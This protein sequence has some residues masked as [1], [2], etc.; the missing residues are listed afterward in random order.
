MGKGQEL[1]GGLDQLAEVL[2]VCP[3][4]VDPVGQG[5][6]GLDVDAGHLPVADAA[7]LR[8]ERGRST[9]AG[10]GWPAR[11][12]TTPSA[13]TP[14]RWRWPLRQSAA[15]TWVGPS[16]S[17][18]GFLQIREDLPVH[19]GLRGR[20]EAVGR[21]ILFNAFLPGSRVDGELIVDFDR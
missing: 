4:E 16:R 10:R 19:G 9:A 5:R 8:I 13:D 6:R 3:H 12:S 17:S 21:L 2:L 11:R 7:D 14:R 1:D 15:G 20:D 18:G